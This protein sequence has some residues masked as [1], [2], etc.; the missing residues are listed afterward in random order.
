VGLESG[1]EAVFETE[2]C[3]STM[4]ELKVVAMWY[5]TA[6]EAWRLD[7]MNTKCTVRQVKNVVELGSPKQMKT[8]THPAPDVQQEESQQ[9]ICQAQ[10]DTRVTINN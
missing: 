3:D 1:Q 9:S 4:P 6:I 2:T 8:R 5:M 10:E 7:L